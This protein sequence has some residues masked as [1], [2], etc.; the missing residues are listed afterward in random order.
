MALSTKAIKTRIKSVKNTKKITKAMEMVSASKMR[1]AVDAA[2]NTRMYA[3]LASELLEH[4][5]G[6]DEPNIPL[7]EKRPIKKVLMVLISSNRGLCGGFNGNILRKSVEL[8]KDKEDLATHKIKS[9]EEAID[10]LEDVEVEV[11][12]IGK[13]SAAFAKKYDLPLI[14][15]FDE[16]SEAPSFEDILPISNMINNSYLD[17]TYDKVVIVY[18]H[19][20][21]SLV[22][23]VKVR[24]ALPVTNSEIEEMIADVSKDTDKEKKED[25]FPI[26]QYIFEPG[27][28]SIIEHVMPR[29]VEIQL[30]QAILESAASEHSARMLAMKNASESADDMV[31]SLTL[32]FNKARQAA[33]TQE[34]A[35][36]SG[37]A[38]AL[39]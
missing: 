31:N 33:I 19:F 7:L 21:S 23:T 22:Q 9:G 26:E 16:L 5:S 3:T 17:K 1:K 12:G 6:I 13:K 36:I 32:A 20:Q 10:V 30:Y 25:S 34:I 8:F 11:L 2:L 37:G 27:L 39:E 24:Q 35:E 28:D 38:A 4:L 15:V 14:A 29:L 18:T